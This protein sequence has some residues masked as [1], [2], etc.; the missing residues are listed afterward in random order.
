MAAYSAIINTLEL[1]PSIILDLA[2]EFPEDRRPVRLW[3]EKWS[4]LEH[5]VHLA[6]VGAMLN[7]RLK[8]M[9]QSPEKPIVPYQPEDDNPETLKDGNWDESLTTYQWDRAEFVSKMRDIDHA[10]WER[11]IVHPEC[12]RY[13]IR[14]LA[15][16]LALHDLLH[17]ARIEDLLLSSP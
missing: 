17:G 8:Q 1:N 6:R 5:V 10:T 12:A 14:I 13:S 11:P 9:I 16:H 4:A 2:I 15:R 7:A 3:P